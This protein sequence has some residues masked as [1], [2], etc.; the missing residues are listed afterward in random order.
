M[1]TVQGLARFTGGASAL[2]AGT[3]EIGGDFSQ[4]ENVG[5]FSSGPAF[6]TSFNGGGTQTATFFSPD[7]LS[8]HFGNLIL[9]GGG[10]LHLAGSMVPIAPR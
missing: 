6:T 9:T 7:T 8:D 5:A 10:T 4:E 2:L 3:L 1:V